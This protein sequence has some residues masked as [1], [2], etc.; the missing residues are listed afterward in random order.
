MTTESVL[1]LDG[2]RAGWVG[3]LLT[4]GTGRPRIV[5]GRTVAEAVAD[6][7]AGTSL[8]VV[9]IDIPIGLPDASVR[10]ADALARRA[11]PGKASSVF[12]T[13]TRAAYLA[14]DRTTA[15]A[16]NARLTGQKVGAQAFSLRAKVLEVDAWVRDEP[17]VEVLEVHPEVSFAAMAGAPLLP[18]KRA[19]EGVRVRLAALRTAG[20]TPPRVTP[21]RGVGTDDVLDAC[22]VAWTAARRAAGTSHSLPDPPEVFSDG[23]P[24]AIHV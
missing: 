21:G 6:V 14:S 1:G 13:L 22:A 2:C 15:S 17:G 20:I 3:A 23:I 7:G 16:V 19:P 18:S 10:H 9:G 8:E 4:G 24:A 12:P 11:V 5:V